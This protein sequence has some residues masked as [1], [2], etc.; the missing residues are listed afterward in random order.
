MLIESKLEII[1]RQYRKEFWEEKMKI[2]NNKY[3]IPS[4]EEFRVGFKYEAEDYNGEGEFTWENCVY[5]GEEIRTYL[6]QELEQKEIRVKHLDQTDIES[7][8]YEHLGSQWYNLKNVPG[9]LEYYLY[10]RLRK[11]TDNKILIL[12]YRFDPSISEYNE[13]QYLFDGI[14]KNKSELE[15]LMKQLEIYEVK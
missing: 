15:V 12:A 6:I 10:V 14:I 5:E 8:G 13:E 4:I 9:S 3:Y 1:N 2:E 7:L 11:W